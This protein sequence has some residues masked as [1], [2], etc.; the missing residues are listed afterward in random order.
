[1]VSF[2]SNLSFSLILIGTVGQFIL[3]LNHFYPIISIIHL[4]FF[5]FCF[6]FLNFL[7]YFAV[8]ILFYHYQS[9]VNTF[10]LLFSYT[11]TFS[12]LFHDFAAFCLEIS[13]IEQQ[14]KNVFSICIIVL[15]EI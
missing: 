10:I 14:L 4:I 6:I 7:Q 2:Q 12:W 11:S 13:F 8:T 9:L 15:V 5:E 1:M 3:D